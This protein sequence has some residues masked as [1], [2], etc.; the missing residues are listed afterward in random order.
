MHKKVKKIVAGAM[1]CVMAT[2]L[3]GCAST[4]EYVP[5][6][7]S[8]QVEPPS[9]KTAGELSVGVNTGKSP[10]AGKGNDKIIGVDVDIAAAL[11]DELGLK[12]VI[13]DVGA[14]AEKAIKDG[15]VDIVM[16]IDSSDTSTEYWLS[17]QY[18]PTGVVLFSLKDQGKEPP[19]PESAPK[20]AAQISSKSAWAVS[21]TFGDTSLVSTNDLATAFSDLDAGKVSYV[22]SDAV[23][24]MY[25]ANL[26]GIE[27]QIVA[28]LD[29]AS[30]Y[31]VA[32]SSSDAA[33][34]EAIKAALNTIST[35]GTIDV[36]EKKWLGNTLTLS[37][38]S[39]VQTKATTEG[40]ANTGE[41]ASSSS[42][43]S[44]ATTSSSS[45]SATSA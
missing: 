2:C 14:D 1:A 34:Q 10:L 26:Q 7:G 45:S 41:G 31:C 19:T 43:S 23:I 13:K 5:E 11:A 32:V 9:I 12:L 8:P 35:N 37:N 39:K 44:A 16:G 25:A 40:D 33:L 3:F 18:L 29:S 30:G 22:A 38:I 15:D 42:S 20:I 4:E 6:L 36:I 27:V 24:G 21:N 17:N 28:L